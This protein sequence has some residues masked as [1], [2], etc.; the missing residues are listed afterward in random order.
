[1]GNQTTIMKALGVATSREQKQ[2]RM[3]DH[4]PW[5]NYDKVM[6]QTEAP[7]RIA[8]AVMGTRPVPAT[9]T[10]P[11]VYAAPKPIVPT[12][13]AFRGVGGAIDPAITSRLVA[14]MAPKATGMARVTEMLRGHP[15]LA[16][17][18][19]PDNG[20][21]KAAEGLR[22]ASAYRSVV[23]DDSPVL[24][25]TKTIG[26]HPGLN[27]L[28]DMLKEGSPLA[29]ALVAAAEQAGFGKHFTDT[30]SVA[31]RLFPDGTD[32]GILGKRGPATARPLK[33]LSR[34]AER[35]QPDFGQVAAAA[36]RN[37]TWG[38]ALEA[39]GLP[40]NPI[41]RQLMEGRTT[42][43]PSAL[44][45]P[46]PLQGPVVPVP[47][48]EPETV[49]EEIEI[50]RSDVI[51]V[52]PET[53]AEASAGAEARFNRRAAERL[54]VE[55]GF[56]HELLHLNYIAE[57]LL[58]GDEAASEYAALAA[59]KIIRG[60]ADRFWPGVEGA[61]CR[62]RWNEKRQLE[63]KHTA[64]RLAAYIDTHLGARLES[65]DHRQLETTL[66]FVHYWAGHGHHVA[67]SPVQASRAY[68]DFL[69]VIAYVARARQIERGM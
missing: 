11:A 7:A 54:L 49:R 32:A 60:L 50:V 33:A 1:M 56:E 9:P 4:N 29:K 62:S 14:A 3:L 51:E 46:A 42:G 31:S 16:A 23:E 48:I 58:R 15:A 25:V 40:A 2:R 19:A 38:Q 20:I 57:L 10:L 21:A 24:N 44:V 59:E 17:A 18:T 68:R 34:I 61:G 45:K 13:P 69:R 65:H 12:L 41:V 26:Q 27:A 35:Q 28:A 6:Q 30:P 43:T 22:G 39:P 66:F 8:A 52:T 53:Y 63:P 64:N 47:I 5:A 37:S 55:E 67:H 36:I